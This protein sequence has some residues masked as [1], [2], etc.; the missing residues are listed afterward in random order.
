MTAWSDEADGDGELVW[1]TGNANAA[2]N[3][4]PS[5]RKIQHVRQSQWTEYLGMDAQSSPAGLVTLQQVAPELGP[6]SP[7]MFNR[8]AIPYSQIIRQ[9]MEACPRGKLL[10]REIYEWFESFHPFY[11]Q[12]NKGW[13]VPV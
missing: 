11:T 3:T 1:L 4:T 7:N 6:P 5:Q 10:L 12:E 9:A 13:K 2:N 8:P